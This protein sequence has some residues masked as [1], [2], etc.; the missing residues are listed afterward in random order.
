M[1]LQ[2]APRSRA[3]LLTAVLLLAAFL[4]APITA[5]ARD[6]YAGLPI[7]GDKADAGPCCRRCSCYA[8]DPNSCRCRDRREVGCFA[9]CNRCMCARTWWRQ[10]C[11]CY[12][13][14]DSCAKLNPCIKPLVATDQ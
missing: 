3:L 11:I 13:A 1:C 10:E 6:T 4:A 9:G 5:S 2:S 12:D 7:R 14:A 8:A